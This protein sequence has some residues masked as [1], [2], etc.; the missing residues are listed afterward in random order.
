MQQVEAELN[1]LLASGEDS[2]VTLTTPPS[3]PSST[4]STDTVIEV[5]KSKLRKTPTPSP[6]TTL[7][8]TGIEQQPVVHPL[9]AIANLVDNPPKVEVNSSPQPF[10]VPLAHF[11]PTPIFPIPV[12]QSTPFAVPPTKVIYHPETQQQW[13]YFQEVTQFQQ[14]LLKLQL[15]LPHLR[16]ILLCQPHRLN[17]VRT[18]IHLLV[19]DILQTLLHQHLM[20]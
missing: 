11:Q 14:D 8:D 9:L 18:R 5:A 19:L 17:A 16:Q 2:V 10:P 4:D 13:Q 12:G 20:V 1:Q 7:P 3:S 15:Q 6:M